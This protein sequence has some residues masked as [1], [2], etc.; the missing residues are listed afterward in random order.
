MTSNPFADALGALSNAIA[1]ATP[2]LVIVRSNLINNI[3]ANS[4]DLTTLRWRT[5][6]PPLQ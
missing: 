6:F 2:G 3:S 4:A 1:V 5:F